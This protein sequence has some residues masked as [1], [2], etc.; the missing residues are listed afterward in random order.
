[1]EEK[2]ALLDTSNKELGEARTKITALM[3]V[4][5]GR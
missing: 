4:Q 2:K 1:V 3:I 5:V